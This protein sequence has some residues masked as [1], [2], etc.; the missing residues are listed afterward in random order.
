ML[1]DDLL[2]F[3]IGHNDIR[4]FSMFAWLMSLI[5]EKD[6]RVAILFVCQHVI[7]LDE[8]FAIDLFHDFDYYLFANDFIHTELTVDNN[9]IH[10][11]LIVW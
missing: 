8:Y 3:F 1:I 7:N 10:V 6:C 2:V 4:V 9:W 11:F 5:M